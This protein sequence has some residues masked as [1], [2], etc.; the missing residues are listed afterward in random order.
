MI[1]YLILLAIGGAILY[2]AVGASGRD[3]E[4]ILGQKR[5]VK[6]IGER[7][8]E[9]LDTEK[10]EKKAER[11]H[12][13]IIKEANKLVRGNRFKQAEKKYLAILKNDHKNVNAY[14][15]LGNLYLEQGEYVG[16]AEALKKVIE[17]EPT[18]E[19]A[20]TSLGMALMQTKDY[21]GAVTAYE[22]AVALDTTVP[23]RYVN[24]ALAAEKAGNVKRQISALAHAV[25]LE[26]TNMGYLNALVNA[27]LE[28][29]DKSEAKKALEKI[30]ELEPANLE[31]HRKLAR[32][33]QKDV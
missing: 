3:T 33:E 11:E 1:S 2:F 21:E 25:D 29:D 12:R 23:H 14:F 17:F 13:N 22:H 16:A 9:V 27:A 19:T 10:T 7:I 30:V 8:Q 28:A 32:L 15:G 31:A 24:L 26:P 4:I 18:N 5:E 6:K 20:L